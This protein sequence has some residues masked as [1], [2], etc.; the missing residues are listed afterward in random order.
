MKDL[1]EKLDE[2]CQGSRFYRKVN[3]FQTEECPIYNSWEDLWEESDE[4]LR[5]RMKQ[6]ETK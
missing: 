6:G 5:N 4:Q 2:L 3:T 1:Q